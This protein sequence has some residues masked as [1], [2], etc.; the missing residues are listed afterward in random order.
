MNCQSSSKQWIFCT[1]LENIL[2][3]MLGDDNEDIQRMAINK[4]CSL[5][6]K[7]PSHPIEND[8]L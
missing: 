5:Q 3:G 7:G 4:L 2:L 6:L 1:P 8:N